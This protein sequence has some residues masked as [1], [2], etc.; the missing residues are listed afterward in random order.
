[1]TIV[2]LDRQRGGMMLRWLFALALILLVS[3]PASAQTFADFLRDFESKAVEAGVSREVYRRATNGLS[4]DPSIPKLVE[5]QPEFTTPIWDYLDTRITEGRVKRGR[6]AIEANRTL[7]AAVGAR[8]GVDPYIL[9]S[10]WG[11]ETDYGA[12]LGNT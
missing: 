6:A 9:G 2:G 3:A 8:M 7:F 1:H 4:P 5:T 11:V 10:I 12:V